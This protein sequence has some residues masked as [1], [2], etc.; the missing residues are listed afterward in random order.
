LKILPQSTTFF[1]IIGIVQ[2][3]ARME[4]LDKKSFVIMEMDGAYSSIHVET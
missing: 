2:V 1:P 4:S 3:H